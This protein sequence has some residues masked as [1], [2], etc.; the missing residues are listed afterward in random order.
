MLVPRVKVTLELVIIT[1]LRVSAGS[2]S[3]QPPQ[4]YGGYDSD[5]KGRALAEL[6]LDQRL[7][8]QVRRRLDWYTQVPRTDAKVSGERKCQRL[9]I[10]Q[11]ERAL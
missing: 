2:R 10:G 5:C 3:H 7:E 11:D 6:G 4:R 8:C 9:F 1:F